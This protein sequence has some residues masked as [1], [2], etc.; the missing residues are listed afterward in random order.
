V[1]DFTKKGY[2]RTK[3]GFVLEEKKIVEVT[4]TKTKTE[5]VLVPIT[6]YKYST[7]RRRK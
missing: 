5:R 3:D 4:E 7:F 2:K 1:T 6:T